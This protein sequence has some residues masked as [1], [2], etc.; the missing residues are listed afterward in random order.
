MEF[1]LFRL[2]GPLASWGAIAVGQDRPSDSHPSKS[3]VIGLL[4]AALGI[5]REEEERLNTLANDYHFAVRLDAPG[6]LMRDYH[7]AQVPSQSELKNCPHHTRRDELTIPHE[8]L[9]TILSYREYRCDALYTLALWAKRSNPAYSLEEM[10]TALESPYFSLYLG[11]KSCPL[12]LPIQAKKIQAC[13]LTEALDRLEK[14]VHLDQT[15]FKYQ[16]EFK[17]FL[18]LSPN[19]SL[20]WDETADEIGQQPLLTST[21]RDVPL[22]RRR[23]QFAERREQRG[24]W[25][26]KSARGG[27]E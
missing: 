20:H 14:E 4:A 23:W 15:F 19:S 13:S 5:R 24:T 9:N 11:R 6:V 26:S 3:A 12:A 17:D 22:S 18:N 16:K 25:D 21:R 2:Y 7:T 27:D 10:A 8:K 1:L